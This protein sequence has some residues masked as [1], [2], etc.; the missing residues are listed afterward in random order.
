MR[1]RS[2]IGVLGL[3]GLLALV[4]AIALVGRALESDE[5]EPSERP[6]SIIPIGFIEPVSGARLLGTGL[7]PVSGQT[8][9]GT[10]SVTIEATA[11]G[12]RI[13][14]AEVRPSAEGTFAV[15]LRILPPR[16]GGIVAIKAVA[17]ARDRVAVDIELEPANTLILWEPTSRLAVD[18]DTLE[19][20]GFVLPPVASV[21]LDLSTDDETLVAE[22]TA[23]VAGAQ[24]GRWRS[25][26]TTLAVPAETPAGC[27]RLQATAI[28]SAERILFS[29]DLPLTLAGPSAQPCP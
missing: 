1:D 16:D 11:A 15:L 24:P 12:V 29:L 4:A 14:S 2:W 5:L 17:D 3:F 26:S 20:G 10:R 25:F 27:L 18:G 22:F 23:Q 13:G 19:V 8:P 7:V 21:R 28:G 9:P 6:A